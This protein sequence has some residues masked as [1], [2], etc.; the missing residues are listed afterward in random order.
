[1]G[2]MVVVVLDD[3]VVVGAVVVVVERA[4]FDAAVSPD[5]VL[6]HAAR[7]TASKAAAA[8]SRLP[9]AG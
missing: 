9:R 4:V 2:F 1:M 8:E 3:V 7:P 5:A 6:L